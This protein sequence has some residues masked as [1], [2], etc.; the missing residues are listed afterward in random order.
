MWRRQSECCS[1]HNSSPARTRLPPLQ[2]PV[3][4]LRE[5]PMRVTRHS[6]DVQHAA[7]GGVHSANTVAPGQLSLTL[8]ALPAGRTGCEAHANRVPTYRELCTARR[9]A[10]SHSFRWP[11]ASLLHHGVGGATDTVSA[12]VTHPYDSLMAVCSSCGVSVRPAARGHAPRSKHARRRE[13]HRLHVTGVAAQH[14][15]RLRRRLASSFAALSK[16]HFTYGCGEA[17]LLH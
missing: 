5:H 11:S 4:A 16:S 6:A 2:S 12:C 7:G 8:F 9:V 17:L 14:R 15:H 3:S 13:R 1:A 10:T